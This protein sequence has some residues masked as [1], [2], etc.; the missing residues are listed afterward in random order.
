MSNRAP[1]PAKCFCNEIFAG[2][3]RLARHKETCEVLEAAVVEEI[4]RIDREVHSPPRIK[5]YV[6]H[7]SKKLPPA[8]WVITRYGDWLDILDDA[9]IDIGDRAKYRPGRRAEDERA[10]TFAPVCDLAEGLTPS[11]CRCV[12][13][14]VFTLL[15]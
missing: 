7:R 15:K 2:I 10:V 11:S 6:K 1:K 8:T 14:E 9:G 13:N 5:D 12:G 3:F 4:R